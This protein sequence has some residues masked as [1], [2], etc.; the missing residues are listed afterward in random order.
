VINQV[1][2]GFVTDLTY[3]EVVTGAAVCTL[4]LLQFEDGLATV[5]PEESSK[6]QVLPALRATY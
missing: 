2:K 5:S 6:K 1:M 4:Q 3:G